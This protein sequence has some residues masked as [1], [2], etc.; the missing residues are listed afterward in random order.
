MI[1][2]SFWNGWGRAARLWPVVV[3][4][5]VVDTAVAL[6]M[7]TPAAAQLGAVFGHSSMAEGLLGP[8]SLDWLLELEEGSQLADFPWLLYLLMPSIFLVITTFLRG[9]V[10]G[11]LAGEPD[12]FLWPEFFS[13]C[14]RHFWRLL[15]LL[16]FLI[17]GFLAAGVLLII[18]NL[19]VGIVPGLGSLNMASVAVRGA[20]LALLL[21]FLL[22]FLDY[23]RIS[24]VLDP[25]RPLLHH[26]GRGIRFAVTRLPQVLP[27]GLLF[28]MA[29]GLIA[30]IYPAL[31]LV[32][33]VFV[34]FW[35]A[36]V[37]QQITAVAASWQRTAMLGGQMLLF[38]TAHRDEMPILE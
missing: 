5:Y 29:A 6:V 34:S 1:W 10:L 22:T 7:A 3:L 4:L 30:A 20:L 12:S 26:A 21:L 24:L 36:L 31:L 32:A 17:P 14:A 8:V 25:D 33:P 16:L 35:P 23:A 37:V 27:L 9:G 11:S 15:F 2:H 18:A 13:N 19:L 38:A 28:W